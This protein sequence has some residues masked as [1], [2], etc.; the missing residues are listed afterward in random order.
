MSIQINLP[1]MKDGLQHVLTGFR[2]HVAMKFFTSIEKSFKKSNQKGQ[3]RY[4]IRNFRVDFSYKEKT[5]TN[6]QLIYGFQYIRFHYYFRL[7]VF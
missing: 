1:L 6:N 2:C 7:Y 5:K 4:G 3:W